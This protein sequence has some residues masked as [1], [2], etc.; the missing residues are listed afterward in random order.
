MVKL[1][2][3]HSGAGHVFS[4]IRSGMEFLRTA[5]AWDRRLTPRSRT[6]SV[7]NAATTRHRWLRGSTVPMMDRTPRFQPEFTERC[8]CLTPQGRVYQHGMNCGWR[9][10][11]RQ[12]P[13]E[14]RTRWLRHQAHAAQERRVLLHAGRHFVGKIVRF[15]GNRARVPVL[16]EPIRQARP[17]HGPRP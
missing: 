8:A 14:S 11:G 17:V 2:L 13:P 10:W 9:F 12:P 1:L 16:L 15:Q 4:G 3:T 7:P 5:A 6:R